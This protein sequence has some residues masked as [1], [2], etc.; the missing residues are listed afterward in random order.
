MEKYTYWPEEDQPPS[1]TDTVF[2]GIDE[3]IA[4]LEDQEEAENLANLMES[5]ASEAQ[6]GVS[7]TGPR[8]VIDRTQQTPTT[9]ICIEC[10]V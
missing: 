9:L 2:M 7:W 10:L 6:Q 4:K 3:M 1:I 5:A 8:V